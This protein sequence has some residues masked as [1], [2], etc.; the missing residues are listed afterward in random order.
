MNPVTTGSKQPQAGTGP[1]TDF[2]AQSRVHG[3]NYPRCGLQSHWTYFKGASVLGIG[4]PRA[5][6]SCGLRVA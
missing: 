3:R 2:R 1:V 5:C 6:L 4:F